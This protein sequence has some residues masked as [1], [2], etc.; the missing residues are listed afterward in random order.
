M[1]ALPAPHEAVDNA[2]ES[3]AESGTGVLGVPSE[4][5]QLDLL[6]DADGKLP[7]N[8]FTLVRQ[9]PE[10]ARGPGRPKGAK[11]K[12]SAGLSELIKHK[13]GCPV[14]FQASLYAM[15]LDQLCELILVA[16]GT[17][18]RRNQLD[19]MLVDLVGAVRLVAR[20]ARLG[21]AHNGS[22]AAEGIDR[23]ADACEALENVAKAGAG[24]PGDVAIKALNLQLAASRVV[25][26]YTDSKKP[27]EVKVEFDAIPTIL[28]PGGGAG[29]DFDQQDAVTRLAGGLLA[30]ALRQG[31]I[32]AQDIIGLEF[33]DGQF[34]V[35]G[36]FVE[37]SETDPEP[38]GDA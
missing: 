24:K 1:S 9:E 13:Y 17:I 35:D 2:R 25:S 16:D 4:A 29:A 19:A 30:K 33:R 37:V 36:E 20:E 32:E 28:M 18:D 21:G 7:S 10:K 15:P 26:E 27:A 14:E 22:L 6:R 11:N 23:L 5:G 38:E 34:V 8:V 3:G 31:R 12:R